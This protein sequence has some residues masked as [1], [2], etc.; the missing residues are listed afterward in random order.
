[1]IR[2][3]PRSTLFPYTTLFRSLKVTDNLLTGGTATVTTRMD[4][5]NYYG[6]ETLNIDLGS[7]NDIFNIQGT[8][9]GSRGFYLG[10][11]LNGTP[12]APGM[13]VTNVLMHDGNEQA[14]VSSNADL[15]S[16]SA[17]G[18]DFLTGTLN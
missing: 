4:G 3:P 13:A 17:S 1:M 8:T 7:N 11:T 2:R 18:F 10:G 9:A 5:I 16:D 6:I 14:F 15:D 12:Y